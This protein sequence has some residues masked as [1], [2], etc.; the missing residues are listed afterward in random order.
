[1]KRLTRIAILFASAT[2]V[3]VGLA[4]VQGAPAFA[5][6]TAC[7]HAGSYSWTSYSFKSSDTNQVE[8]DV[9]KGTA[10]GGTYILAGTVEANYGDSYYTVEAYDNSC[11]NVGMVVELHGFSLA[12]GG[13][14]TSKW[15]YPTRSAIG[16]PKN[17]WLHVNGTTNTTAFNLPA[18]PSGG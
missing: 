2:L 17:F 4:T 15:G 10:C 11:D 5:G 12:T 18:Y 9:Y 7:Q 6:T 8:I 13:C 16:S 14:K 1:M 3:S